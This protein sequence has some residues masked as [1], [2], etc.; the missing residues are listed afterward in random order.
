M[1]YQMNKPG[2]ITVKLMAVAQILAI[3]LLAACTPGLSANACHAT[4]DTANPYEEVT[5]NSTE[6]VNEHLAHPNDIFPVPVG[7]CPASSVAASSGKI[8]ICHVTGSEANPYNEIS[9]SVNGLNGHGKHEGDIIPVPEGG[10][11]ANLVVSTPQDSSTVCHA[12]GDTANSYEELTV[13]SAELN[14]H[15]GHPNDFSPVPVT[16]CPTTLAVISEGMIAICHATGNAATPYEEFTVSVDGLD[17]HGVHEGDIIPVPEGGCPATN[18]V[19]TSPG[20]NDKITI[21]HATGSKKNPYNEITVSVNGLNG[22]GQHGGDII[23]APAGGCPT[24]K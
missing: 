19:V 2:K 16:G 23:P 24:T 21:C 17:G 3:T 9:V 20:N 12:T 13:T 1:E 22:H 5:V 11:P 7:G 8:V 10:C 18:P 6:L 14:E 4:G 15:L